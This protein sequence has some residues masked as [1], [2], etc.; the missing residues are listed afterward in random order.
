MTLAAHLTRL[1]GVTDVC[2]AALLLSAPHR[3]WHL[4]PGAFA[5]F[6]L[7]LVAAGLWRVLSPES[8]RLSFVLEVGVLAFAQRP[9]PDVLV[10]A[11]LLG[12]AYACDRASP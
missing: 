12:L 3:A 4:R 2:S 10:H 1:C 7:W 5:P 9:S 11:A 6:V 8:A